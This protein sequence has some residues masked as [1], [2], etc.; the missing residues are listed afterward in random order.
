M[1]VGNP[2]PDDWRKGGPQVAHDVA[3]S[4]GTPA[5]PI[6]YDALG[7][8]NV[9]SESVWDLNRYFEKYDPDKYI[10]L[11]ETDPP[12]RLGGA[13]YVYRHP[14]VYQ[15]TDD[16]KVVR[17][18][19]IDLTKSNELVV[20]DFAAMTPF[21]ARTAATGEIARDG[22]ATPAIPGPATPGAQPSTP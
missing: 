22:S 14:Y 7:G 13:R 21:S 1:P 11:R 18:Q 4:A 3:R 5:A 2:A 19:V 15:I 20:E 16:G 6:P 12:V 8:P 17:F 9:E 10:R